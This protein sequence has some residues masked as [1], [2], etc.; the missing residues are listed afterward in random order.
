MP[1]LLAGAR[2]FIVLSLIEGLGFPPLEAMQPGVPVICSNRTAL[3][4]VIGEAG[5]L[6]DPDDAEETADCICRGLREEALRKELIAR[7]YENVKRFDWDSRIRQY[8]EV[9]TQWGA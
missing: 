1:S 5:L 2:A 9:L 4:E 3:P 7:E 6:T 8:W